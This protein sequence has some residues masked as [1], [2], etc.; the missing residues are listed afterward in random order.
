M[1]A[2]MPEIAVVTNTE[3]ID[4]KDVQKLRQAL[5]SAGIKDPL[6]IEV[7]KGSESKTAAAK[8]LKHG[9]ETVI[10][11][12]GDGS[13]RAASEALVGTSTA[14]AVVPVGTANLF[15]SGLELPTDIEEI[16]DVVVRGDRRS[17]DTAVCNG[18][19]FN[20]MAGSG[21]DVAMLSDAED[22][23]E[24]L[25][26]LA[27]VNAAVRETRKRKMFDTKVTV[28]GEVFYKGPAS[29][30]LVGN[31]GS[32][33]GGIDA[34]PDAS[35]TDG[36]LHVAVVSATGMRE[37]ASLMVRAAMRKQQWSGHTEIAEGSEITVKFDGKRRFELDGG[38]KGK[39]KKLDFEIRPRSLVVCAPAG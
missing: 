10:V 27:Y 18:L 21:F 38:V 1:E 34:F 16:V 17:L 31:T 14:L 33:K 28:D 3:K 6:W 8:A 23:K 7:K 12:G 9:A 37:W 15:A 5:A 36:R 2:G 22:G 11:C 13:V 29:C 30:V 20:V 25:G 4:K 39:A 32:L 24:R 19:T 35:S 26:T